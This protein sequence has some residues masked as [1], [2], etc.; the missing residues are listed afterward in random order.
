[1]VRHGF[2]VSVHYP[3]FRWFLASASAMGFF[4]YPPLALVG[5]ISVYLEWRFG[6]DPDGTFPLDSLAIFIIGFFAVGLALSIAFSGFS[7]LLGF[8]S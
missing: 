5:L 6:R 4:L 1:M 7:W 8:G 2:E 3:R